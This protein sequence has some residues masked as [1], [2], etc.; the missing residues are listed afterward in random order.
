MVQTQ[1]GIKVSICITTY[2]QASTL[3][4]CVQGLLDQE[5]NFDIEIIVG[6]DASTDETPKLLEAFALKYPGVVKPIIHA[7]N[8]GPSA[9]YLAVHSAARGEYIAHLDGDDFS[10]PGKLRFQSDFLN[11]NPDCIAVVHRMTLLDPSGKPL[12]SS[13]PKRFPVEKINLSQ[14]LRGQPMFAHST[15]MYRRGAFDS[16]WGSQKPEVV[17]DFG[18][19]VLLAQQGLIGA[20][21]KNLGEYTIGVG[22]STRNNYCGIIVEVLE[23]ARRDGAADEDFKF[24]LAR[25]YLIFSQKALEEGNF[26]LFGQ[27]IQLSVTTGK[28][29]GRQR[30]LF[31]FR[32]WPRLLRSGIRV[33]KSLLR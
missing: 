22:V 14:L 1:N 4:K 23:K 2:N 13:W 17:I 6:D 7:K 9:N 33:L 19:Y 32:R 15:L 12:K 5:I 21:N 24:G 28:V 8:V 18:L 27:L 31:A 16:L 29:S 3:V 20:I 25:Q 11:E 30:L 10:L 26:Q